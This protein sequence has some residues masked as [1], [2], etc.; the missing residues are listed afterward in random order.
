KTYLAE[1]YLSEL[2]DD[3]LE[4][5]ESINYRPNYSIMKIQDTTITK[6][7]LTLR[8]LYTQVLKI[9]EN[10]DSL[11]VETGSASLNMPKLQL[12]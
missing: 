11:V 10:T 3:L 8:A 6:E 12:T 2:L 1:V 5:V 7:K 4:K 9:L